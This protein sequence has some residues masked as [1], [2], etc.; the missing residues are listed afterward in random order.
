MSKDFNKY[1]VDFKKNSENFNSFFADK[2]VLPSQSTLLAENFSANCHFSKK[3]IFQIISNSDSKKF[4][5]I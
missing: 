3:D 4:H 1:I 5:D 2:S